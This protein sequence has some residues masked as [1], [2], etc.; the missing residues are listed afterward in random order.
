MRLLRNAALLFAAGLLPGC[1]GIP[2]F[3]DPGLQRALYPGLDDLTPQEIGAAFEKEVSIRPPFTAGV[4]WIGG[5]PSDPLSEYHRTG[6]LEAAVAALRQDPFRMVTSIPTIP[7]PGSVDPRGNEGPAPPTLD[8]LRG[9]C[10]R[11]QLDVALLMQTGLARDS[12]YNVFAIGY[13]P[14]VTIPLF[15]GTDLAVSASVEICAID[16]RSG[17]LLGCARGRCAKTKRFVFPSSEEEI[18][19]RL[20]EDVLRVA[21]AA[22]AEDLRAQLTERLVATVDRPGEPGAR[23]AK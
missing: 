7:V 14:L 8:A 9:A 4:A 20:S 10:A 13:L 5:A 18:K 12:G 22:A 21:V 19:G 23:P 1:V 3:R 15:P 11:F 2:M 16:V 17:V 6:V